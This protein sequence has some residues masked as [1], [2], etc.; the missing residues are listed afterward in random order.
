M[1][2]KDNFWSPR[3][4][5][6][7]ENT[8][9][10][11][12]R[13]L[14]ETGRWD[15]MNLN[16]KDGANPHIFWDSDIA[17][18]L[19]AVCYA[20]KYID[21]NDSKY[22]Q[23]MSW[24]DQIVDMIINVQQ[25][26]GYINSY[27]TLIKPEDK[28]KNIAENHEL[29]T[30]GH[31]IEAAVAHYEAT[32]SKRLIE[33]LCRFVDLLY[34]NFGKEKSKMHGYPGHEEIELALVKFLKI[35]PDPKYF[36]LLDYFI[37]QRGY[38]GGDFYDKQ[39]KER[40]LNPETY[41]PDGDYD[42]IPGLN[43]GKMWPAPKSYWYYQ[44]DNLIRDTR[45]AKGHS[46]RSVYYLTGVQGLGILK[47]DDSLKAIV[48]TLWTNI[49]DQKMYIHGGIGSEPRWEGFGENYDLRWNGYS[50]TC[51]SIG[52]IFLCEKMLEDQL[53]RKVALVMERAL[54]NNI[55]GGVSIDGTSYFYNQPVTGAMGLKRQS[56][57]SVSCCPPNV[58][59]LFNSLEKYTMTISEDILAV[60]LYIGAL[61][62][63]KGI[64]KM[65]IDST[66]PF[67]GKLEVSVESTTPYSVAIRMPEG[68]V[69]CSNKEYELKNGYMVFKPK[70][71]DEVITL[72]FDV[73]VHIIKPNP[74]VPAN[75]GCLA[76][77]R[78]PFVY[79]LQKSGIDANSNL[80]DIRLNSKAEF[81][82]AIEVYNG[83][84]YV[85]LL[86]DLN[87]QKCTFVP[88]FVTG[89]HVP[90]EDFRIWINELKDK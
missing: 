35:V 46:V 38:K 21:T 9:P 3:I 5:T 87:G 8:L 60:H 33:C 19:E 24:V 57:F 83:V 28:F 50:E 27:F 69:Y 20:L 4:K 63:K 66:Y 54:H 59:R 82:E 79:A 14:H 71:W 47:K 90:G 86:A 22:T 7:E 26:D 17:K 84:Q 49:V 36:E 13:Q 6:V 75:K 43:F 56:W 81:I 41:L 2:I 70:L 29:Y 88:Y 72:K 1:Q 74:N 31:L 44:A 23:Y 37:E 68:D 62:E 73:P 53:E 55:L 11:M 40:G 76:V 64:C 34:L 65:K 12:F 78:G 32:G 52:L 18:F 39:A 85:S 77:Q 10:S 25:Q 30:A 16:L 45:E 51:A 80:D 48:R 89:N 42:H 58:A 67:E 61:Y 15:L